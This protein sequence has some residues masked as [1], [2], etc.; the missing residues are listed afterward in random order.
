MFITL[1]LKC[2]LI[3]LKSKLKLNLLDIT[4]LFFLC[5]RNFFLK[6]ILSRF[7]DYMFVSDSAVAMNFS[8]DSVVLSNTASYEFLF[9]SAINLN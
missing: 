1:F 5:K 6:E 7:I 3:N 8:I 4:S 9:F 2:F